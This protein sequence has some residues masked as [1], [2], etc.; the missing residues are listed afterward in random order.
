MPAKILHFLNAGK[1]SAIEQA[2][3]SGLS[4]LI[5][6][7]LVFGAS[8]EIYGEFVVLNSYL[9]LF[10]GVQNALFSVP[11]SVEFSA[12][13][14]DIR[15]SAMKSAAIALLPLLALSA[16]VSSFALYVIG[17]KENYLVPIAFAI[18]MI[19]SALREFSR[20]GRLVDQQLIKSLCNSLVYSILCVFLVGFGYLYRG[21]FVLSDI[22]FALGA[23]GVIVS[24]SHLTQLASAEVHLPVVEIIKRLIRHTKW[25][26]PGVFIIWLQNNAYLTVVAQRFGASAAGELAAARLFV[27]PYLT[28]FAGYMR[29]FSANLSVTLAMG[30]KLPKILIINLLKK[31]FL[32]GFFLGALLLTIGATLQAFQAH[33][34]L[35]P[36]LFT[37]ALW[38]I[39]AGISSARGVLTSVAHGKKEFRL[40]FLLSV[41]STAFVT[42]LLLVAAIT[43]LPVLA[44]VALTLGELLL[45][46]M[47][48]K[49]Y[50]SKLTGNLVEGAN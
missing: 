10:I 38:A 7:V 43:P 8:K 27:M 20:T 37:A 3:L 46:I 25:A 18:A 49:K 33:S 40:L 47:L 29:P 16:C 19:G 13:I 44:I 31:Q 14:E 34:N 1:T 4:L 22:F 35:A 26:L 17:Q 12:E 32:I 6:L 28:I 21:S 11:M 39:F 30:N 50:R 23:A 5:N 42:I 15:R 41:A 2:A 36:T 45:L 9:L 24:F 48:Y